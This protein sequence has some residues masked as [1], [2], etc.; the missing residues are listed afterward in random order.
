MNSTTA[1]F[2]AFLG[3]NS[4]M[5]HAVS[6]LSL[7]AGFFCGCPIGV[8]FFSKLSERP[9][10][11]QRNFQ[12]TLYVTY[13]GIQCHRAQAFYENE[14]TNLPLS[15]LWIVIPQ[16]DVDRF[17]ICVHVCIVKHIFVG[18][19]WLVKAQ[20]HTVVSDSVCHTCTQLRPVVC[21]V[22]NMRHKERHFA[23][24]DAE[25]LSV[26]VSM[27]HRHH[28]SRISWRHKSQTKLQGCSKCHIL[29]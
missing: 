11:Q 21:P 18:Y 5:Y 1:I 20:L 2:A 27:W 13:W 23:K 10:C 14:I 7:P 3:V 6:W 25:S 24:I 4:W 9:D 26:L 16:C 17:G 29:G 8:D 15:L 12:T 28:R 22:T 19:Y